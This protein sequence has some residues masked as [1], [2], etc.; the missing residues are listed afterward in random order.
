MKE[1]FESESREKWQE[2]MGR[3][4]CRGPIED[5]C[6]NCP[7]QH[8]REEIDDQFGGVFQGR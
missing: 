2:A 1:T 6:E 8:D 3:R 5:W 4:H 7:A